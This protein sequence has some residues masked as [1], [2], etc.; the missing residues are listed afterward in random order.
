MV[1]S[2][3]LQFFSKRKPTSVMENGTTVAASPERALFQSIGQSAEDVDKLSGEGED[4]QTLVEEI[5]S[6]CINC[7]ENV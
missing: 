2:D 1:T 4:S 3:K 6:M 5:E 7:E